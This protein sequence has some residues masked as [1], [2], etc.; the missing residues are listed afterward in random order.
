MRSDIRGFAVGL[1]LGL[2]ALAGFGAAQLQETHEN[3]YQLS[4]AGGGTGGF[5]T[6]LI[7]TKTANVWVIRGDRFVPIGKPDAQ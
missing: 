5:E 2:G 1:T 6:Y 3:R 7:D 4:T